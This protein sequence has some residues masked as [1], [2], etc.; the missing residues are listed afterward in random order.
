MAAHVEHLE[1]LRRAK[2]LIDAKEYDAAWDLIDARLTDDPNHVPALLQGSILQDKANRVA[3][4]YQMGARLIELAP[5]YPDAWNNFGRYAERLYRLDEAEKSYQTAIKLTIE[6]KPSTPDVMARRKE[7]LSHYVNN[8]ASCYASMG[9]FKKCEETAKQCL[10]ID[11]EHRKAIGNLGLSQI[12]QRKWREGWVRYGAIL[13]SDVRR[14][15][16]YRDEPEWDGTPNK[17]VVVYGE[18]GLGDELSFASMVPDAIKVCRKVVIDCDHRLEGIFRRSF[19]EATVY[20][21]RWE[22]DAVWEEYDTHPNYSIS[23]GQL[24]R[25]FRTSDED[26]P[27]TPYLKADPERSAMWKHLFAQKRKPVI[28]IAW[29]GGL[30][31]TAGKFR[32]WGLED[33]QPL[34]DAVDAHWVSLQYKDASKEIEAFEGAQIH[35]YKYATLSKDY[36]DTAAL[37]SACDLVIGMQTS[38][39]HLAAALGV[40]TWTF[41]NKLCQWRY[42]TDEMLWYKAMKLYR[43]DAKGN[44]PIEDA[45]KVLSLRYSVP[46]RKR[47]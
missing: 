23:I 2:I 29:S 14:L 17:T 43:Q 9:D 34:F 4:A 12:A 40:E 26:F 10:E 44:W 1:D 3:M 6:A 25:I 33:L 32:K 5:K 8:L 46:E 13:G 30:P 39:C 20:G 15:V 16:K 31:W 35:Q 11:P 36:D 19:P 27:G 18:Q 37:V 42:G 28:G 24:G 47:A 22:K 41:V 7:L 38:V 45:A 21:T